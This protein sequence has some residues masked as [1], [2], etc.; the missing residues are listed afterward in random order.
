MSILWHW[1]EKD[2]LLWN[3]LNT[4]KIYEASSGG[5][6]EAGS[7]AVKIDLYPI[8]RFHCLPHAIFSPTDIWFATAG[9]VF[10]KIFFFQKTGILSHQMPWTRGDICHSYHCRRQCK[11]FASGVNF[12]KIHIFSCTSSTQISG[13]LMR[14]FLLINRR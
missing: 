1:K 10:F 11:I 13:S 12:S 6:G 9:P 2:S 14:H 8:F 4:F 7:F 3:V 5:S